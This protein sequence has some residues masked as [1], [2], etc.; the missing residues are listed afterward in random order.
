MSLIIGEQLDSDL[1]GGDGQVRK[2]SLLKDLLGVACFF[3]SIVL[4]SPVESCFIFSCRD[5]EGDTHLG[6]WMITTVTKVP[7]L[8]LAGNKC[9]ADSATNALKKITK[10]KSILK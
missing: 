4:S 6:F 5:K 2:D 8:D 10:I 1:R 3:K 9:Y 7:Y